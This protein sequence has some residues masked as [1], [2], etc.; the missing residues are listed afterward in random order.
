M[1]LLVH[2][3]KGE[4]TSKKIK[5]AKSVFGVEPNDH[6]V[7][8]SVKQTL[9]N[10]RQGTHKAKQRNEISGSTRKL[11]KQKGTGGARAGSIKNPQFRGGGRIF[12]PQPRDYGFKLNKKLKDLARLSALT[13]KAKENNITIVEDFSFD[14]PATKECLAI[15][16]N[17]K[18]GGKKTLIVFPDK[19]R[20]VYLS[21]RN[22]SKCQ[23]TTADEL[24]TYDIMNAQ[25][26][27]L[28]ES[29]VKAIEKLFIS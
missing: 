22:I 16:N 11:K 6:A 7:Y 1:E 8:L 3:I 15:I 20:N 5:L 25:N 13:Y 19:N 14:A 18:L 9:A 23:Y 24:N 17:L 21:S 26:L 12:G 28:A 10:K 29:S 4:A 27:L 2:N